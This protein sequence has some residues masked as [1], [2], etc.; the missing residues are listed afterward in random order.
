M[1]GPHLAR[2]GR[3]TATELFRSRSCPQGV[4]AHT[5]QVAGWG[6]VIAMPRSLWKFIPGR[7]NQPGTWALFKMS[8]LVLTSEQAQKIAEMALEVDGRRVFWL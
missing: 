1:A 8:E 7:D 4:L 3:S 5:V 6:E 2:E